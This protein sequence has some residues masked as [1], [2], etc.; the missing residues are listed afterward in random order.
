MVPQPFV[1]DVGATWPRMRLRDVIAL[2]SMSNKYPLWDILNASL[3]WVTVLM[4]TPLLV[5]P[6]HGLP[7]DVIRVFLSKDRQVLIKARSDFGGEAL[8]CL[9]FDN[10]IAAA[11]TDKHPPSTSRARRSEVTSPYKPTASTAGTAQPPLAALF[12]L[13]STPTP[14]LLPTPSSPI[15]GLRRRRSSSS[16]TT[17][18][19]AAPVRPHTPTS[20]AHPEPGPRPAGSHLPSPGLSSRSSSPLLPT[21]PRPVTP[22][23]ETRKFAKVKYSNTWPLQRG[24]TY[25]QFHNDM[26][27]LD[28]AVGNKT[29]SALAHLFEPIVGQPYKQ[30]TCSK[31]RASRR[32][33]TRA[34]ER[35]NQRYLAL[36]GSND[37]ASFLSYWAEAG[38]LLMAEKKRRSRECAER[39]ASASVIDIDDETTPFPVIDVDAAPGSVIDIE[40]DGTVADTPSTDPDNAVYS[41]SALMPFF[42]DCRPRLCPACDTPLPVHTTAMCEE[43]A[44]L[45]LEPGHF[46]APTTTNPDHVGGDKTLWRTYCRIHTVV[47]LVPEARAGGWPLKHDFVALAGRVILLAP[48]VHALVQNGLW[49]SGFWWYLYGLLDRHPLDNRAPQPVNHFSDSGAA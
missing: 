15:T 18:V 32:Y 13:S 10:I 49:E 30:T 7:A 26:V 45:C 14:A 9:A 43:L 25:K 20:I 39:C 6:D 38:P 27:K 19:R 46:P 8:E 37:S 3:D 41:G 36:D 48:K 24:Y 33:T 16:V 31:Y 12:A 23:P 28:A 40:D 21:T 17:V 47:S 2:D 29:K 1:H 44:S 22:L 4:D 11:T 42:S 34:V 35:I 5:G